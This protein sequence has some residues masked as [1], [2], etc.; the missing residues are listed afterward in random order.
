[1]RRHAPNSCYGRTAEGLSPRIQRL[2][3][4]DPERFSQEEP[5]SP[6]IPFLPLRG[7]LVRQIRRIG[8]DR[9]ACDRRNRSPDE[10]LAGSTYRVEEQAFPV[11]L[12]LSVT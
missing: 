12:V 11:G 4:R 5:S 6:A 1:M 9:R 7:P 2:T 8:R 3:L 10:D